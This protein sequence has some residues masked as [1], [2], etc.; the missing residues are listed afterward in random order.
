M[1]PGAQRLLCLLSISLKATYF[2]FEGEGAQIRP[3]LTLYSL[4]GF[5]WHPTLRFLFHPTIPL[6]IEDVTHRH[7]LV[8]SQ[9]GC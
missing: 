5:P 9:A 7:L 6:T 1:E 2:S 4:Q 8:P 3:L